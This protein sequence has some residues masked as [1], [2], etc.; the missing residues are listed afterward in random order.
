[1]LH[2]FL[3]PPVT[4]SH[5]HGHPDVHSAQCLALCDEVFGADT[6]EQLWNNQGVEGER[7]SLEL[8]LCGGN[9]KNRGSGSADIVFQEW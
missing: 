6:K 5:V 4:F 8:K 2:C 9:P 3:P 1:M 7:S